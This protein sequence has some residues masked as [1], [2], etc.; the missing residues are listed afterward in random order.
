MPLELLVILVVGGIGSIAFLLHLTGGSLQTRLD[1]NSAA[2]A[3]K[4]QFPDTAIR[5]VQLAPDGRAALIETRDSPPALGLVWSFG[6]DTVARELSAA[7]ITPAKGGLRI[8]FSDF[9]APRASVAL[10]QAAASAWQSKIA[11]QSQPLQRS[12]HPSRQGAQP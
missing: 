1:K 7:T 11:A 4:R 10:P 9:G 12:A 8:S 2:A 5:D 6:A 3:W